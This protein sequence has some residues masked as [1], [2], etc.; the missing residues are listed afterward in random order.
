MPDGEVNFANNKPRVKTSSY[1]KYQ[2]F[3]HESNK[4]AYQIGTYM[5]SKKVFNIGA[6]FQYQEKAMSDN[7]AQLQ[8]TNFYDMKHFAVDSF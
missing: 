6:G 2:F 4:S 8:G 7:D 5:Q 1:V 3:E